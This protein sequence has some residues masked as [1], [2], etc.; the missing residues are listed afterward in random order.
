MVMLFLKFCVSEQPASL[1]QAASPGHQHCILLVMRGLVDKENQNML[2]AWQSGSRLL[3]A[4]QA[5]SSRD[6][7]ILITI[8]QQYA[9]NFSAC[10]FG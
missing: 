4:G 5:S 10:L 1:Q 8:R 7:Q 9:L 2:L 6:G 3:T